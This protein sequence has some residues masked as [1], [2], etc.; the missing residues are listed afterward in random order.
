M[1]L[2]LCTLCM[3][4]MTS[5]LPRPIQPYLT[6]LKDSHFVLSTP[7]GRLQL[8]L[9]VPED[10][11]HNRTSQG[12]HESQN[13]HNRED[14]QTIRRSLVLPRNPVFHQ[15]LLLLRRSVFD[16]STGFQVSHEIRSLGRGRL[17]LGLLGHLSEQWDTRIGRATV[18][19]GRSLTGS[20]LDLEESG[21][22]VFGPLFDLGSAVGHTHKT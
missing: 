7:V 15:P 17:F 2:D 20:S 3:R 6:S 18:D 9:E 11:P 12:S 13:T 4:I 21:V 16:D 1:D 14:D 5:Y 22:V 19:S 8:V 10:E